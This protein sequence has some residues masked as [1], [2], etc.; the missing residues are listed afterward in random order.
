MFIQNE[1]FVSKGLAISSIILLIL[2]FIMIF[3]AG[4]FVL[5]SLDFNVIVNDFQQYGNFSGWRI[6]EY[7]DIN[8]II[9]SVIIFAFAGLFALLSQIFQIIVVYQWS[10]ALNTNIENTRYTFHQLK[11]KMTDKSKIEAFDIIDMR[12][13]SNKV[14]VW[15]YWVYFVML[16]ISYFSFGT[17]SWAALVGVIFLAIYIHSV[18]SISKY[19]QESKTQLYNYLGKNYLFN[20]RLIKERNVGFFILFI[21][22]TFGIYWLYL[23]IKLSIEINDYLSWDRQTRESLLKENN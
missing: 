15:A 16:L 22:I 5:T 11:D 6:F 12:F 14:Q 18:F 20:N 9:V 13:S 17:F 23:I 3:V 4:A 7:I 1:K 8:Q 10:R 2:S 21:I 19:L